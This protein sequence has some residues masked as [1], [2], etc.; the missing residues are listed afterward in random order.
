MAAEGW[1]PALHWGSN[2]RELSGLAA[3]TAQPPRPCTS[4]SGAAAWRGEMLP[5]GL[6]VSDRGASKSTTAA[7][8]QRGALSRVQ[9]HRGISK[10]KPWAR[11]ER[12][13]LGP[14]WTRGSSPPPPLPPAIKRE[15]RPR[16]GAYLPP[17]RCRQR[18]LISR[19]A[20]ALMAIMTARK[21]SIQSRRRRH[22]R[23]HRPRG[24]FQTG[25]CR[26]K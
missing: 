19:R 14:G 4:T 21:K 24:S 12:R 6:D 13:A 3:T 26:R 2:Q 7:V 18:R 17:T 5:T 22:R 15:E 16:R 11:R 9:R 25:G 20:W 10:E 8:V 1:R 23:C